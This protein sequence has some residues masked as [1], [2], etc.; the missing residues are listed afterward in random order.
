MNPADLPARVP[1]A[2]AMQLL[3]IKTDAVFRKVVE[4]H[5]S[6]KGLA[7]MDKLAHKLIGETR[8]K[9]RTRILLAL[10]A[11]DGRPRCATRGGGL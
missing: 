7:P 10:L 9:Y 8:A 1:R 11:S 6:Q 4:A 5:D 2:E 3:G